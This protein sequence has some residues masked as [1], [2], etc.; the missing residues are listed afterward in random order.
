MRFKVIILNYEKQI[1][2]EYKNITKIE[3]IGNCLYLADFEKDYE[4]NMDDYYYKYLV[5]EQVK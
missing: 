4:I 3:I 5:V 1:A 2:R